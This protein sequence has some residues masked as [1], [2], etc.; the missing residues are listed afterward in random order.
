MWFYSCRLIYETIPKL[1]PDYFRWRKGHWP[2]S[3]ASNWPERWVIWWAS[4]LN[5]MELWLELK[6][7]MYILVI[8]HEQCALLLWKSV[9]LEFW[10]EWKKSWMFSTA[11]LFCCFC[12]FELPQIGAQCYLECSALTQKGLKTVFDE[13][14]LTIFSPKKK[15]TGCSPCRSCCTIVWGTS[16]GSSFLHSPSS[17]S[18]TTTDISTTTHSNRS[19]YTIIWGVLRKL[20]SYHC[21]KNSH[22]TPLSS[23]LQ[24]L[25]GHHRCMRRSQPPLKYLLCYYCGTPLSKHLLGQYFTTGAGACSWGEGSSVK[26][27]FPSAT[28]NTTI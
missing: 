14:I 17:T 5:V 28:S 13:A 15:K 18:S 3:R 23:L 4:I 19:F 6:E 22:G 16:I 9:C 27:L 21:M 10:L 25:L 26:L 8:K 20:L 2:M 12:F 24:A 11:I 1:C 7:L